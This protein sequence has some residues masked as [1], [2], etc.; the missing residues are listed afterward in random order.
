M[1]VSFEDRLVIG[2]SS[3]ALFDMTQSDEVFRQQGVDAYRQFQIDHEDTVL[4]PGG[5]FNLVSKLLNLNTLLG[6]EKV[7]VVLLSRNTADTG[8][9]VFN[10]I[11]HYN[12]PIIRAAFSGGSSPYRYAAD[13]GAHLF[14]STHSQDVRLA[15][16]Q[17]VAAAAILPKPASSID[18]NKADSQMLKFAFD[19]DAVLFTDESERIFKEQGLDAFSE[20]ELLSAKTPLNSGPFRGFLLALHHLQSEFTQRNLDCPIRTALVTARS[21]PAHERVIRT[22]REW[23]VRI[24]ESIFLGGF[25][26]SHFLKSFGAD[27]FFDDQLI[28]LKK[29]AEFL[30]TGHVNHG[31]SNK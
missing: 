30:T 9:R 1:S 17:N 14:L 23:G 4:E 6:E 29:A 5:A 31:V 15:L 8:L 22:L 3:S 13:F 12:L 16:E 20:N 25:E 27:V 26:K 19:G 18:S 21:A 11:H 2:I 28:H 24:D 7:E 10:S